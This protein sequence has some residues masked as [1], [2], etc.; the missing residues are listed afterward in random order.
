MGIRVSEALKEVNGSRN[1]TIGID[2][3]VDTVGNFI[4]AYPLSSVKDPPEHF[5]RLIPSKTP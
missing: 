5:L 4:C 2:P 3:D 1:W